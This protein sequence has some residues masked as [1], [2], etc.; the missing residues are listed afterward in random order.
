MANEARTREC[1]QRMIELAYVQ[2]DGPLTCGDIRAQI[3]AEYDE[4]TVK[5][6]V[7]W[8]KGVAEADYD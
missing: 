2:L 7:A 8:I 6:A 5:A 4:P 3:V 1:V